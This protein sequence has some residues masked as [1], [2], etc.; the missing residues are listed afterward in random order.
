MKQINC[1]MLFMLFG[2]ICL[3]Q[4]PHIKKQIIVK[5]KSTD[6]DFQQT[7]NKQKLNSLNKIDSIHFIHQALKINKHIVEENTNSHFYTVEY[8]SNSNQEQIIEDYKNSGLVEYAEPDFEGNGG[9]TPND[10][11]FS[12]QW[13]LS[14]NGTFTL[15]QATPGADIK[16]KSAWDIEQG[17]TNIVVAIIDSG[18]KLDHP[19]FSGRI[20]TNKNEIPN[21]LIDD[22]LN[23]YVDDFY[24]WDFVNSDNMPTDDLGHG[25]CVAGIIGANANNSIGYAGVD[26]NCKLMNLKVL[27][28]S[29]T[30]YY[31]AF[32]DAVYYAVHQGA[33]VINMSL[34]GSSVSTTFSNAVNYALENGVTVVACMMNTNSSVSFYPAAY[35]GVIAVGSTNSNDKRSVPFFWSTSSGSNYGNHISVVAPGNYIYAINHLSNTNYNTYWGGTS[36][37][38]PYV[39]GLASLLLSQNKSRNPAQIKS[40]IETTAEDK[41]GDPLEDITGWD[42]YYGHGRINAYQ[43]L[44]LNPECYTVSYSQKSICKGDSVFLQGAYRL[45]SGI[46]TDTIPLA[47]NCDSI[48]ICTLNVLNPTESAFSESG[49]NRVF[50]NNKIYLKSGIYFDTIQNAA[51]CD[52]LITLTIDILHLDSTIRKNGDTLFSNQAGVTYQW[53]DC[54]KNNEL[55]TGE[56]N[57]YLIVKSVGSYAVRLHKNN[58]SV[59]SNC[60]E[61]VSTNLT[62]VNHAKEINIFPNPNNGKFTIEG[63]L[64]NAKLF[65][66]FDLKG[67]FILNGTLTE[68]SNVLD[69]SDKEPGIY[70]LKINGQSFMLL[71]N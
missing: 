40:I 21:N 14:N 26:W 45:N 60:F 30:G 53:L 63:I 32:A 65:E 25:T 35:P 12:R 48:I 68:N 6:Q 46:F 33:K 38:T 22:D 52:S 43:A 24:G 54:S 20:W 51:G 69:I 34:G 23:G 39:A 70:L 47:K 16:M 29:N 58:C 2:L 13:A 10:Q 9:G 27:N 71:K 15:S 44:L 66:I 59:T 55:I 50:W 7:F 11:Y 3:A 67:K 4:N 28:A 8:P 37:A 56:T 31:S 18:N 62:S 17:D 57:P 64:G 1:T 36:Q 61:V 49:C 5:F 42:P 19:E 41:V